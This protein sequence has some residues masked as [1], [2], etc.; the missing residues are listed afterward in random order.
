MLA[1]ELY[2]ASD[3]E[4]REMNLR[5]QRILHAFNLSEPEAIEERRRLIKTLF[6]S[7]GTGCEIKPPLQ[8]DYGSHITCGH[9]V[10]INYGC[11]ILDC[12]R[13]NIGDRVLLGPSVQLYTASHPLD[14]DKRREGWELALPIEIGHDVWV[15]GSA[16]IC[17]GVTIG[18]GST[19]GAGS[20]VTKDIPAGVI[21][22]GNP[23]RV[24]RRL[25]N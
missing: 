7:V 6:R 14:L 11:V 8:C 23:C 21:A 25:D 17:P 16:V 15:G 3:A 1:G 9:Q 20:V 19:I 22:V 5:A 18:E 13:V 10:F 4:L 12:N 24:V 2:L